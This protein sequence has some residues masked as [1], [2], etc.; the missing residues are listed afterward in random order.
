M[1]GPDVQPLRGRRVL[2]DSRY[3]RTKSL[4]R[5]LMI[6]SRTVPAVLLAHGSY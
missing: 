1:L 3:A 6:I 5:D 4:R 2:L